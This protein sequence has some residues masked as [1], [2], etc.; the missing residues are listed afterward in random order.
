[1]NQE[2]IHPIEVPGRAIRSNKTLGKAI[3]RLRYDQQ[4]VVLEALA[5]ELGRQSKDDSKRGRVKLSALLTRARSEAL[6]LKRTF[7][8]ILKLCRPHMSREF[9][10][11]PEVRKTRRRR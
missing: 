4:L 1:M 6:A 7:T 8:E 11:W 9:E 3:G 5:E 10:I 2:K